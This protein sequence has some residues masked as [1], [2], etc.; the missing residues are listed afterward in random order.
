M[1]DVFE[2]AMCGRVQRLLERCPFS[3]TGQMRV[4]SSYRSR[5]CTK[6]AW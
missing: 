4:S 1:K 2:Q 5:R 3:P 6:A